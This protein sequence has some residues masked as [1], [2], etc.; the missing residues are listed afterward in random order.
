MFLGNSPIRFVLL[1]Y[2]RTVTQRIIW[3]AFQAQKCTN[4]R[5]PLRFIRV[6]IKNAKMLSQLKKITKYLLNL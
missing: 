6:L 3:F 5:I 1:Q 4:H 2:F